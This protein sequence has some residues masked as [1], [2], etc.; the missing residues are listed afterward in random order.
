MY[1]RTA[2][3]WGYCQ[4]EVRAAPK[5]ER[6]IVWAKKGKPV[7]AQRIP[8]AI[9]YCRAGRLQF[10]GW[11]SDWSLLFCP[12]RPEELAGTSGWMI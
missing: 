6:G 1:P 9:G 7:A 8:A 2:K 4:V 12:L 10:K 5:A 3:A 11:R